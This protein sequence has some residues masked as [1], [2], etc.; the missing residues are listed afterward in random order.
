MGPSL[1]P[2]ATTNLNWSPARSLILATMHFSFLPSRLAAAIIALSPLSAPVL[3]QAAAPRVTFILPGPAAPG[4]WFESLAVRPNG[5]L[6]TTRGDAPEIWQIDP[7]TR[8]GSLLVSIAAAGGFNL[9]GIAE[10][11]W[12]L[13][14]PHSKPPCPDT[15]KGGGGNRDVHLRLGVHPRTAASLNR[16]RQG[17]E[18]HAPRCRAGERITARRSPR[19]GVYQRDCRVG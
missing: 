10:V 18:T 17:V 5:L 1:F 8:T 2:L 13:G 15:G 3:S 12:P 11:P 14:H 16:Q 7:T 6:L 9:T 19:G 4:S